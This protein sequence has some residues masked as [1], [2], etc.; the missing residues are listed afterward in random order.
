MPGPRTALDA[1]THGIALAEVMAYNL[2]KTYIEVNHA[3]HDSK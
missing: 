2:Y 1:N 3:Y